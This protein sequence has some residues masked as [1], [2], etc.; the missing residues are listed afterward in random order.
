[1]EPEA[2]I[3]RGRDVSTSCKAAVQG[4]GPSGPSGPSGARQPGAR[5]APIAP[6]QN[7]VAPNATG[8]VTRADSSLAGGDCGREGRAPTCSS[9]RY[10]GALLL[11]REARAQR[12]PRGARGRPGLRGAGSARGPG[13]AALSSAS[14]VRRHFRQLQR[15]SRRV[16]HGLV[17][18]ATTGARSRRS[19][20]RGCDGDYRP[21][22][23][24]TGGL[25]TSQLC[26]DAFVGGDERGLAFA[27]GQPVQQ[28]RR[29]PGGRGH[30]KP[31]F[32]R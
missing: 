28:S 14:G 25:A 26:Y 7:N 1:M 2:V 21:T 18:G 8:A 3:D 10:F 12:A 31:G 6:T 30:E 32:E 5:L 4:C 20:G 19:R 15:T 22:S 29:L 17:A 11:G 23:P 9:G 13:N 24:R 16:R 27:V